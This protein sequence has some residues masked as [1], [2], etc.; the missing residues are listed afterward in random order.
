MNQLLLLHGAIGAKDQLDD[1]KKILSDAHDVHTLNFTGHGGNELPEEPFTMDMFARDIIGYL[2]ENNINVIDI[3]GYS[4]GGYAAIHT[5]LNHKD[6]IGKIFTLATKFEWSPEIAER[7]IKMLDAEK[8]K[9]KV[10]KFA[11]ELALRH[12]ED[13]WIKLL[14]KTAEMMRELGKGKPLKLNQL[15]NEAMISLG[16]RDKM[17]SLEETIAAYRAIPN[18]KLLIIPGTP[19]PIEQINIGILADEIK[20]FL[21]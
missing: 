5:A 21:I 4:M 9:A 1:F 12:G 6:R 17:V 14:E 20:R 10:P 11:G 3:F 19:H 15:S 8:I 16:D 13:N 2:D 7:E 18:A